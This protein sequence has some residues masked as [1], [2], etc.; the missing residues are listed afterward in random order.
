MSEFWSDVVSTIIGAGVGAFLAFEL[1][2]RRRDA[3]QLR[4]EMGRC[5]Q[6]SCQLLNRLNTL[7]DYRDYL[8]GE[9]ERRENRLPRWNEV[10]ALD[11]APDHE[12]SFSFG[13]FAFL[14]DG[15][16]TE[17]SAPALLRKLELSSSNMNALLFRLARRNRLWHE[18]EDA[19]H[20]MPVDVEGIAALT[21]RKNGLAKSIEELTDWLRADFDEE[22]E[23][24]RKVFDIY[25]DVMRVLYPKEKL[26]HFRPMETLSAPAKN[27][28][29]DR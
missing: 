17:S 22:I 19:Q 29:A 20:V 1:E 15:R 27:A 3:E 11:G 26:L 28:I 12:E 2:R 25:Y 16:E 4:E 14:I 9:F 13:D 23:A 6:L 24:C 7:E 8:F 18:W 5:H 21:G 10:P